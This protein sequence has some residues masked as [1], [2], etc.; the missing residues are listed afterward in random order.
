MLKEARENILAPK[1]QKIINV[2][3]KMSAD[4][5][6]VAM[7]SRTHGQTA[8]PTTLGK[9]MAVYINRL[10][11]QIKQFRNIEILGKL[12]GAVGN[13]NAHTIGIFLLWM[14]A[15]LILYTGYDYVKKGI[16]HAIE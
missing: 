2:L 4:Y 5:A 12:N 13:Y 3:K 16:D 11:R 8:S 15:I 1:L 9:E 10:L 14:S 6:S 7:L